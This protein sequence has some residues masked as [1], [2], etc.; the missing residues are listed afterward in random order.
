MA[1]YRFVVFTR[2]LASA[3]IVLG[4][5]TSLGL[6]RGSAEMHAAVM[7]V[8]GLLL[9]HVGL[10]IGNIILHL[11]L[12]VATAPN[13]VAALLLVSLIYVNFRLWRQQH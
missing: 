2:F 12:G 7:L 1:Y 11:P 4:T 6:L 8:G 5:Y 9:T 10:G 3:A 13:G